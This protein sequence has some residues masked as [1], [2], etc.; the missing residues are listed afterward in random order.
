MVDCRFFGCASDRLRLTVQV[1][2]DIDEAINAKGQSVMER[3]MCDIPGA[4]N[5]ATD[6]AKAIVDNYFEIED[7]L[8]YIT[9]FPRFA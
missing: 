3:H 1:L 7:H 9:T 6:S 4:K 5:T 2:P 8:T